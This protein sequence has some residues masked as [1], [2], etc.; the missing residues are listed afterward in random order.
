MYINIEFSECLFMYTER[1]I[2][3][4]KS[5][6]WNSGWVGIFFSGVHFYDPTRVNMN[7]SLTPNLEGGSIGGSPADTALTDFEIY[8]EMFAQN[9]YEGGKVSQQH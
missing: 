3:L 2:E 1:I 6:V 8:L 4:T 9:L 7:L 5:E